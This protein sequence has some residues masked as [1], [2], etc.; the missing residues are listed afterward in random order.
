M[1]LIIPLVTLILTLF[2]VSDAEPA[3]ITLTRITAYNAVAAQTDGNPG[4]S[5]C[6]PTQPNQIAV[7]RDLFFHN[8]VK[9]LC[10]RQARVVTSDGREFV[11]IINDTMNPRYANAADILLADVQS[12][13]QF[14][15]RDGYLIID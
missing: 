3:P 11:G 6:G 1:R 12:A 15:V 9:H 7:S 8:G 13:K 5:S 2:F 14:G 4:Q 10:G